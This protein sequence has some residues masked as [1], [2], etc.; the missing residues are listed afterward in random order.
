MDMASLRLLTRWQSRILLSFLLLY[1]FAIGYCHQAYYRDPGSFFFNPQWGYQPNY[2][3]IRRQQAESFIASYSASAP[4]DTNNDEN[5]DGRVMCIGIPTV[6]RPS[7][8]YIDISVGSLLSSLTQKE[9]DGIH[10]DVLFAHAD[11]SEH[12]SYSAPWVPHLVDTVLTYNTSDPGF[13]HLRDLENNRMYAE[14]GVFDYVYMLDSCYK[15]NARY[16]AIFEDDVLAQEGWYARALSG[17][18]DLEKHG[19]RNENGPS[20]VYMRLFYTEKFLGWNSEEWPTYTFWSICVLLTP[21]IASIFLRRKI[22]SLRNSL[23]NTFISIITLFCLPACIILYFMAGRVSMQP[24]HPGVNLMSNF[25]CCSQGLVFPREMVPR[26]MDRLTKT[27]AGPI[28]SIIEDW[29]DE[30]DL[31]RWALTPSVVQH[32]GRKSAKANPAATVQEKSELNDARGLWNFAFEL[33]DVNTVKNE[34][35]DIIDS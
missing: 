23:S 24:L 5:K 29:A 21:A 12:P 35:V 28:D 19:S 2:S 26:I 16:I 8:Q 1:V 32:I 33:N 30:E 11:P 15:T 6:K 20:W 22:P 9:R 17:L 18:R 25:G 10:M 4:P 3:L 27:K 7:E 14:K 31:Q 13:S 34:H